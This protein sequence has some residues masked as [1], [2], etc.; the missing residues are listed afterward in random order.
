MP[1]ALAEICMR[2]GSAPGDVVLGPFC[3]TGATGVA[4]LKH[5]RRFVGIDLLKRFVDDANQRLR[6]TEF[7]ADS[8][9]SNAGCIRRAPLID[10]L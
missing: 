1:V 10:T 6:Q 3:G 5:G 4:A 8:N 2:A 7:V 9:G